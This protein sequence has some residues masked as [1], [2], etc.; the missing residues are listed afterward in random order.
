VA[1]RALA[2][3]TLAASG[4]QV[5]SAGD[6]L[7]A[8]ELARSAGSAIDLLVT[9]V[10]LPKVN[11]WALAA[12]LRA[13][14]PGLRILFVSGHVGDATPDQE[15]LDARSGFLSKPFTPAT[16]TAATTDLLNRR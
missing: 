14:S 15:P 1:V 5:M 9:D 4:F 10:G 13:A 7:E 3:R 6:G 16:L 8:I 2:T 11:G 12:A